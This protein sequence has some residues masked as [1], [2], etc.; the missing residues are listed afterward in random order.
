MEMTVR[1]PRRSGAR[2]RK[3]AETLHAHAEA[4]KNIKNVAG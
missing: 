1:G 4:A 2:K 3:W